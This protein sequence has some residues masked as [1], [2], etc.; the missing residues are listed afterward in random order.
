MI[1]N[2]S[3]CPHPF[4]IALI[5][6]QGQTRRQLGFV[7]YAVRAVTFEQRRLL[8]IYSAVDG[9][10]KF[11]GGGVQ[12]GESHARALARELR[13]EAGRPLNSITALLGVTIELDISPGD[14]STSFRMVSFYYLCALDPDEYP[15]SLDQYEEDL[16]FTPV[17]ISPEKAL[18][19]NLRLRELIGSRQPFW[20]SR[21]IAVL[22]KLVLMCDIPG[23]AP[24]P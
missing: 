11:P 21:E 7:R 14:S 3:V 6:G 8:M 23:L 4:S 5:R 19:N 17:W 15:L 24:H 10:Y 13:E 1:Y 20:L 2:P 16:G 18:D 12:P 9:D 22:E